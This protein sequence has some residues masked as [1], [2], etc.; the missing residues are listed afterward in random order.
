MPPEEGLLYQSSAPY[1]LAQDICQVFAM[2]SQA[3]AM[4]AAARKKAQK[5]S[6]PLENNLMPFT[7]VHAYSWPPTKNR[8]AP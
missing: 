8:I 7:A 1:V 3:A 5:A 4:G 6:T 2:G